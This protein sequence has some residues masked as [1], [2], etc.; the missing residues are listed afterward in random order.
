M[1]PGDLV[2]FMSAAARDSGTCTNV[3]A[4]CRRTMRQ[5]SGRIETILTRLPAG[6]GVTIGDDLLGWNCLHPRQSLH[7]AAPQ[8]DRLGTFV[9]ISGA[10]HE[11]LIN[12][13]TDLQPVADIA[14]GRF[15]D[16]LYDLDLLLV[17]QLEQ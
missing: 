7:D 16:L 17:I 8:L 13:G 14:A 6:K 2:A 9:G 10:M 12:I 3:S 11:A 4:R 15:H 1:P 5:P